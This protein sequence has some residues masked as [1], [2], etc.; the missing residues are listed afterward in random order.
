MRAKIKDKL[1]E[2]D[3]YF[4]TP[5]GGSIERDSIIRIRED[6]NQDE[7]KRI[8]LS[9]KS[10]N[11]LREG[12]ETREEI[13]VEVLDN[14]SSL[15]KLLGKID[16]KP[17]VS[18][19][20]ERVEYSLTYKGVEFTVTLDNV[21]TLGSFVEIELMSS[22]KED[23]KQLSALGEEL[24]SKLNLDLSR[25]TSLGYHEMMLEKASANCDQNTCKSK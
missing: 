12:V 7:G 11:V 20:K 19:T 16:V 6:T 4:S 22:Q 24:A 25:K 18:V 17:L 5:S 14:I 9:Y 1:T 8:I 21:D 13:E 3:L 23:A 2:K 10:P 15:V